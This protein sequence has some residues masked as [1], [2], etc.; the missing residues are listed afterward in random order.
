MVILGL[1]GSIGMGKTTAAKTFRLLGVPVHDADA[2]IH[3]MMEPGGGAVGDVLAAFPGV[4]LGGAI[5]RQALGAIVFKD[6]SKLKQLEGILHPLVRKKKDNFLSVAARRG[7][8][9]VVLDIPLLLETGGEKQCDGVVVVSAPPAIQKKRVMSRPGMTVE[10]FLS[11]LDHQMADREKRRRAD[12]VV[13]TGLGRFHSLREITQIVR[14][15]KSWPSRHWPPTRRSRHT[16]KFD[17][18][19]RS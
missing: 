14:V 19:N 7:E 16:R 10:R 2:C 1:T 5:D 4:E 11:I 3:Q 6:D 15:T 8:K 18:R 12:F 9:L 17:A 13:M